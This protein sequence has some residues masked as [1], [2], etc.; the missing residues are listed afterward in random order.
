MGSSVT[1]ATRDKVNTFQHSTS[2]FI[3]LSTAC[4]ARTI[5]LV[6][7]HSAV[8]EMTVHVQ[9]HAGVHK[10]RNLYMHVDRR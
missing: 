4:F 3:A 5:E 7:H 9:L 8:H 2:W 10:G 6:S 1:K